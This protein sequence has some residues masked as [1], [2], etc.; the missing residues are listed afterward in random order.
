MGL[1]KL[2]TYYRRKGDDV[3]FFKGD[4]KHFAAQ[5]LCE[6]FLNK[7]NNHDMRIYTPRLVEFI[8]T[9][10]YNILHNIPND[11]LNRLSEKLNKYRDDYKNEKYSLFDI[12]C[13][14]T[15]F[16]FYWKET[17]FTINF[18]KKLCKNISGVLIGGI[19]ASLLPEHICNETGIYPRVGILNKKGMLDKGD[20]IIIDNLPLDYSILEEIDY[21]YPA[22]H[23]YFA[24]MTRGCKRGCKF[25]AVTKLEPDYRDYLNL[26]NQLKQTKAQFG[27]QKDLLLLDNNVLWS[28]NYEKIIDEIKECGFG[29]GAT[30]MPPDE[31]DI[32]ISNLYN[33][34]N[35]RAY[36]K[37]IISI[38]DETAT[39]L[40]EHEQAEFYLLREKNDCLYVYTA[41]TKKICFIDKYF[42]PLYERTHKR[43]KRSRYVD[44]NQGIDARLVTIKKIKKLAEINIRPLRLAFDDYKLHETYE[45]AIR[46]AA[47]Y[48]IKDL[49]NYL[50]YN[51][52]DEPDE[53]YF[54]MKLNIDL[55]EELGI[56]IY[57][58]PMKFHPIDDPEYFSNRDYIGIHWNR[59]FIRAVQAVLNA[60]KGKIGR[61]KSFFEE[62]FG[63]NIDE[64]HKILWMPEEFIIYRMSNKDN[65]TKKWWEEYISLDECQKAK[66]QKIVENNDI[67]TVLPNGLEAEIL[68]VLEYFKIKKGD[69]LRP[70]ESQVLKIKR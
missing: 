11:E 19:A 42:R 51:Y 37:K 40:K 65:L 46:L 18:A 48:G 68:H 63:K 10:K 8:K 60:T 58:F 62:A 15:L 47:K 61:G 59:K 20:R 35:E 36:I 56:S 9:G 21:K 31:Y 66:L 6:D 29:K 2:A 12:V 52:E 3:R 17:I 7:I 27:E 23:A 41:T 13:I 14:T 54:R 64:F 5:L 34:F 30:Y 33:K 1:M 44:F 70:C 26:R 45:K 49:S 67:P 32:A 25:C 16:T 4:L 57:S 55:C 50:L 38:Y 24:Y 43:L 22:N 69:S 39:K 28:K 53:L